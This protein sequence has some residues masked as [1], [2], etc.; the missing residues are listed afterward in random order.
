LTAAIAS[1][2][3]PESL[4]TAIRERE[5]RRRSATLE[6]AALD[7]APAARAAEPAIRAEALRLLDDWK[8]LL[9]KH[10]AVSQ[11]LRK[12][13]DRERFV[14]DVRGKGDARYYELAVRPTLERFFAGISGLK[15]AVASPTP[16]APLLRGAVQAA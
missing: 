6:L 16:Y 4:L 8:G 13:L 2:A 9:A 12:L 7:A 3:A 11:G 15:K 5:A 14:F 10:V 1:G